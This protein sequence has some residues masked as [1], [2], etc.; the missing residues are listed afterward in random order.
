MKA[1]GEE[2]GMSPAQVCGNGGLFVLAVYCL[3]GRGT[4]VV[5]RVLWHNGC[6]GGTS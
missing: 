3:F 4:A 6:A 5:C 1:V 2:R